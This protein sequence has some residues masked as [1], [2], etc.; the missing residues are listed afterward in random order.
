[1]TIN[2]AVAHGGIATI[3]LLMPVILPVTLCTLS[4]EQQA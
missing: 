3:A 1:M 4:T 2:I